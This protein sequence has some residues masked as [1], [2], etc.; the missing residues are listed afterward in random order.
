MRLI[1]AYAKAPI[2]AGTATFTIEVAKPIAMAPIMTVSV[3]SQR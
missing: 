3:T 2:T 1:Q